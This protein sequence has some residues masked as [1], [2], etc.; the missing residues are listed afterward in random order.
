ML[1]PPR[2]VA[3]SED[4]A[5]H[6]VV[7]SIVTIDFRRTSTDLEQ[8]TGRHNGGNLGLTDKTKTRLGNQVGADVGVPLVAVIPEQ[9]LLVD[10]TRNREADLAVALAGRGGLELCNALFEIGAA[11]TAQIRRVGR[12]RTREHTH[13]RQQRQTTV[14]SPD[15]TTLHFH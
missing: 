10:V 13:R 7:I 14:L 5:A 12:S 15:H 2:A 3:D 11:V 6:I 9:D 8:V 1:Q 4:A